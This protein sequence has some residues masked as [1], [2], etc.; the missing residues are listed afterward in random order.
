MASGRGRLSFWDTLPEWGDEARLWAFEQLAARALTQMEILDGV[1]ER[2]R[3]AAWQEGITSDIPQASRSSLN[4]LSMRRAATVRRMAEAKALYE[5]LATQFDHNDVDTSSV[6]LG[7]F[8]KS[9]VLEIAETDGVGTK[10]A[11]ELARAYQSVVSGMKISD[12]RR[13]RLQA[14]YDTRTA[15]VI[16]TAAKEGGLSAAVVAQLRRDFLG[17]RPKPATEGGHAGA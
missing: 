8:L 9:L 6:V 7:E 17:V 14:D 13:R 10:G 15:K 3:T 4:R 16:E 5:G 11:M 12:D 2:L 1:N